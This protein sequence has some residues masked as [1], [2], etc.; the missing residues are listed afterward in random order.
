MIYIPD[1]I[2]EGYGPNPA[3]IETLV[4]NGAQL[5]V[6]VD[7]G[8]TSHE[9][10]AVAK[11]LGADVVVID[12]HQM[13]EELPPAVAVVN[14]NRQDDLSGQGHLCAAGVTFL[15]LIAV[16]RQLRA[17]GYYGAGQ[18]EP[19]LL[20]MLDLVA[21]A[22][23]CDVVPLIGVNRAFVAQGLKVMHRRKNAGLRA[24]ADAAGPERRAD[25][26]SSRLHSRPAH[27]C[28]RTDRRRGARRAAALQRG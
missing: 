8:S 17:R 14:P 2:F 24:L 9:P 20:G 28:G 6:T 3:A 23:V 25:A 12:H 15:F 11:R 22:T 27:Q 13:G 5:I 10:L 1:R 4:K 18:P 16:T 19:D 26:L 7:C 21:L